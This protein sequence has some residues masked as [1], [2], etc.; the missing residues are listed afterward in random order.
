MHARIAT[1]LAVL[2]FRFG[3]LPVCSAFPFVQL[4]H[5]PSSHPMQNEDEPR[6]FR[7]GQ[8]P[9]AQLLLAERVTKQ[10]ASG[11][12]RP[13]GIALL[14]DYIRANPVPSAALAALAALTAAA[15][16]VQP[17]RQLSRQRAAR[18][19]AATEAVRAQ[20]EGALWDRLSAVPQKT[21]QCF[22]SS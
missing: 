11:R 14:G 17:F 22:F 7:A 15:T 12:R 19:R 10:A 1:I 21:K 6:P 3:L 13:Q 4:P 16:A 5:P 20:L 18:A 2:T 9:P 8:S